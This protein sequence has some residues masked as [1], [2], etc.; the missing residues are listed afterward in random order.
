M[1]ADKS[2]GSKLQRNKFRQD[3]GMYSTA[4]QNYKL[5]MLR[6]M[7][8]AEGSSVDLLGG[9]RGRLQFTHD[10]YCEISISFPTVPLEH[11]Y[12][13]SRG[14]CLAFRAP[15]QI[16]HRQ[17]FRN[18]FRPAYGT[19]H[20]VQEHLDRSMPMRSVY[21]EGFGCDNRSCRASMHAYKEDCY[22]VTG[23]ASRNVAK[24]RRRAAVLQRQQ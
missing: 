23:D 18:L 20:E 13:W 21:T 4:K 6:A 14:G 16:G 11:N 2:T 10:I 12:D 9:V 1:K 3:L 17:G 19:F 5:H 8:E 7:Y 22:S 15:G 24:M